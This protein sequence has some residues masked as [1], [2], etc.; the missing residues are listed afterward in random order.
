M[1]K[2]IPTQEED[3]LDAEIRLAEILN[4]GQKIAMPQLAIPSTTALEPVSTRWILP[5]IVLAK[6]TRGAM[7]A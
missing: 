6:K 4:N 2:G 1:L 7:L 5:T 3:L